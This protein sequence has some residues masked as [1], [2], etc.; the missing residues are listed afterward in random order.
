MEWRTLF[1]QDVLNGAEG[2][3]RSNSVENVTTEE[4]R[5]TAEAGTYAETVTTIEP[6]TEEPVLAEEEKQAVETA[7]EHG[8]ELTCSIDDVLT[9]A[10]VH[11]GAHIVRD[12][13]IKNVSEADM[14]HLMIQISS[15]NGL[16]EAFK[17][18]IEK[19]K[20]GEELHF[21]NLNVP[22]YVTPITWTGNL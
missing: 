16:T 15:G 20:S 19:I 5:G 17:L 6:V 10:I 12:I 2:C 3:I 8:L 1:K 18:G 13:C 14:D 9:Y 7:A 22:I 21:K 4:N 11:N